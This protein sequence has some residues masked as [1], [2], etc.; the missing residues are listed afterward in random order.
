MSSDQAPE[1]QQFLIGDWLFHADLHRLERENEVVKLEPRV[2]ELLLFMA[3]RP[4]ESISRSNLMDAL[5]PNMVVGD[6]ALS[7]AVNKLR[8]AL[9][10]DHHNPL[11]IETIPKVG[12]RLI[13]AVGFPEPSKATPDVVAESL[14]SKMSRLRAWRLPFVAFLTIAV[15]SIYFICQMYGS[16]VQEEIA[17]QNVVYSLAV[18]PFESLGDDP[19]LDSR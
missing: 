2:A 18:M 12:Y 15:I 6:E 13:A 5:W 4:G 3:M 10:D 9:G 8:K 7:N 19:D 14:P 16:Q 11:F 1:N 17:S